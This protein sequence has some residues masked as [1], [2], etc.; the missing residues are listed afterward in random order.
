MARCVKGKKAI[1][2][3][4]KNDDPKQVAKSLTKIFTLNHETEAVLTQIME[5]NI[6][7]L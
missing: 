2:G 7:S 1:I 3:V 6:N 5:K 4:R